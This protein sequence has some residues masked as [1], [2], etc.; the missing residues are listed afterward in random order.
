M[1]SYFIMTSY[2]ARFNFNTRRHMAKLRPFSGSASQATSIWLLFV[3]NK[4]C[5][6]QSLGLLLNHA[7]R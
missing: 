4:I 3:K 2:S 7:K 5:R 1:T 6:F